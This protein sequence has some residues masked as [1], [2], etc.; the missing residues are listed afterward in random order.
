MRRS[1]STGASA[2]K[3]WTPL[4]VMPK[5]RSFQPV[6]PGPKLPHDRNHQS[7]SQATR[8]AEMALR[9]LPSWNDAKFILWLPR[10]LRV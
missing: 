10:V 2:L 5:L 4:A 7:V 8:L 3:L 6:T 9:K 1:D